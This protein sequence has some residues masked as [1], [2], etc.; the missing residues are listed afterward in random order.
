LAN[1]IGQGKGTFG[2][3]EDADRF[4]RAERDRW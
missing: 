1:L 2:S 4:I 3:A